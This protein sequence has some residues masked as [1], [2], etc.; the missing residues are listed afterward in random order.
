MAVYFKLNIDRLQAFHEQLGLQYSAYT[1]RRVEEPHPGH[2]PPADRERAPGGDAEVRRR[3]HLRQ[4][5]RPH[6]DPELGRA[7][8]ERAARRRPSAQPFFCGPTFKP[9]GDCGAPTF[10]IKKIDIPTERRCR[11]RGQPDLRRSRSRRARTRSPSARRRRRP[12]TRSTRR[13]SKAGMNYVLLK[14][15]ES[16]KINFWVLPSD[17]GRHAR[18]PRRRTRAPPSD[19]TPTRP[20]R[21]RSVAGRF[22]AMDYVMVPVPEEHVVDVMQHVAARRAGVGRPL[23]RR[24]RRGALR[25]DRR[26]EPLDARRSSRATRVAGKDVTT[27]R[28]PTRSELNVRE[29]RAIVRDINE[30]DAAGEARADRGAPRRHGRAPQRPVGAEARCS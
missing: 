12:S 17:S 23:G 4:R 7:A 2:V 15:I 18:S 6:H 19:A 14:A 29:I 20:P 26:G 5:R 1:S 10:I 25:R 24:R 9:G 21:P 11:L 27:R 28:Q 16:G 3:R 13:S 8:A 30:G 22:D